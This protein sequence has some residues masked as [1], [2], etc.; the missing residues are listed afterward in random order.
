MSQYV[1]NNGEIKSRL[2]RKDRDWFVG[3]WKSSVDGAAQWLPWIAGSSEFLCLTTQ[4]R[5][6]AK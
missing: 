2:I 5:E 6:W 1:F 4:D 3:E